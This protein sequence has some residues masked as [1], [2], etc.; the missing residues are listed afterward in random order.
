MK[1]RKDHSIFTL[2]ELLV[3]IAIIAILAAMLLPA[4]K[5]AREQAKLISCVNN[6]KQI[7]QVLN[8][9]FNDYDNFFPYSSTVY[10]H[11]MLIQYVLPNGIND[12]AKETIFT[13][14]K[15]DQTEFEKYGI[16]ITETSKGG[17]YQDA[18]YQ[19][20]NGYAC[21]QEMGRGPELAVGS[22]K[23]KKITLCPN[24]GKYIY[25]FDGKGSYLARDI[26][27]EG[28]DPHIS[29]IRHNSSVVV[30]YMDGHVEQ[31]R[32]M[33]T[34]ADTYWNLPSGN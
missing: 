32:S 15:I 19:F 26:E 18:Y 5:N 1:I 4:L 9:Y 25:A 29:R 21:N 16:K 31:A 24:P 11:V 3:V 2:I 13:C 22:R 7:G 34:E 23:A 10:M 28:S 17:W 14:P 33:I 8:F 27:I 6:Q 12:Y 30:L 20:R